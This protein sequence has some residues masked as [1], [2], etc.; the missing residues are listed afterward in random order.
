MQDEFERGESEG[1][2]F[3]GGGARDVVLWYT[4]MNTLMHSASV[5]THTHTLQGCS[6]VVVTWLKDSLSGIAGVA[7]VFA[8]VQV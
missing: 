3:N 1:D 8:L 2:G 7:V 5:C 6:D 4:R